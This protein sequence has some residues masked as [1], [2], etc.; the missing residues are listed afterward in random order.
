MVDAESR[1]VVSALLTAQLQRG[2]A[3]GL[4]PRRRYK[5]LLRA[6]PSP[7]ELVALAHISAC[8]KTV[9]CVALLTVA[10]TNPESEPHLPSATSLLGW[11]IFHV[12]AQAYAPAMRTLLNRMISSQLATF[13]TSCAHLWSY[14]KDRR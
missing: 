4:S 12:G 6:R 11:Q 13:L 5:R 7:L 9:L 10:Q 8:E 3:S 1:L 2:T 14:Q